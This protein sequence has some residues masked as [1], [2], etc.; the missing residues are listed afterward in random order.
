MIFKISSKKWKNKLNKCD[1]NKYINKNN[2]Y[3]FILTK[4]FLK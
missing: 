1:Y 2:K 4:S 3:I